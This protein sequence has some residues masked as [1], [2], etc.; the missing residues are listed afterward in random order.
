M[1]VRA[2]RGTAVVVVSV[3]GDLSLP[4]TLVQ[5]R[6][7]LTGLAFTEELPVVVDMSAAT[8]SSPAVDRL[9]A[10]TQRLMAHRGV[11]FRVDSG[12]LA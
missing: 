1:S 9:L 4:A 7:A 11:V 2:D 12:V 5:L 10:R 6:S 3:D 8:G